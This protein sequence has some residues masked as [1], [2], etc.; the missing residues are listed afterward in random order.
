MY[1]AR[2]SCA[3]A[4]RQVFVRRVGAAV[5]VRLR[6][7]SAVRSLNLAIHALRANTESIAQAEIMYP[8]TDNV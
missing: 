3:C 5:L 1:A 7:S 8:L 4:V 2:I 6:F